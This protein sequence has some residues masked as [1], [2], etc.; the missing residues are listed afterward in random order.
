MGFGKEAIWPG[1]VSSV[2][3]R[4]E[5]VVQTPYLQKGEKKTDEQASCTARRW[6]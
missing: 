4:G 2:A 3:T 5:N 6:Q 1:G